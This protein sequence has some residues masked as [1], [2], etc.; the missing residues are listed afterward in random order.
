MTNKLENDL[1]NGEISLGSTLR[2]LLAVCQGEWIDIEKNG[3]NLVKIGSK[4]GIAIQTVESGKSYMLPMDFDKP[5]TGIIYIGADEVKG[6][7]IKIKQ[8]AITSPVDGIA[9]IIIK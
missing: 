8:K 5:V 6:G 4:F 2:D 3:W 7:L 9:V 1:L